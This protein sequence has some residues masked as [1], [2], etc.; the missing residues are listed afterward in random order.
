[1]ALKCPVCGGR[2]KV[3]IGFRGTTS[4]RCPACDTHATV[5]SGLLRNRVTDWEAPEEQ[6]EDGGRE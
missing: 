5:T 4:V 1:M 2:L 3:P 6:P